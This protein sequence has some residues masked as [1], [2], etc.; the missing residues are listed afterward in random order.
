MVL[1]RLIESGVVPAVR[2]TEVFRQKAHSALSRYCP[3]TL[4]KVLI[5]PDLRRKASSPPCQLVDELL[6]DFLQLQELLRHLFE[7]SLTHFNHLDALCLFAMSQQ[8]V[9][10]P[11][12]FTPPVAIN[13]SQLAST[14]RLHAESISG[15]NGHNI[16]QLQ[17][18]GGLALCSAVQSGD[19][20]LTTGQTRN[21][22]DEDS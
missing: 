13:V 15:G 17:R 12:G 14:R 4:S 19:D 3:E 7:E 9:L 2:Q 18:D 10:P 8:P 21:R 11:F 1:R 22:L 6:V 5:K 20:R 16:P